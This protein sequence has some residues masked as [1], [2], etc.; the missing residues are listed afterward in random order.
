MEPFRQHRQ[1]PDVQRPTR[2]LFL[3]SCVSGGGAGRSLGAILSVADP[4][5]EPIVAMP[6][7]GVMA[8]RLDGHAQLVFV[9][10]FV[11]RM[12]RSPYTWPD[13]LH[14]SWLHPP[15]SVFSLLRC[16]R[17]LSGVVRKFEPD[18]IHCNHMLAKPVGVALGSRTGLPV[19]FH[20]R[21]CHQMWADRRLYERLGRHERV[22]RIICNSEASA[23]AYRRFSNDKVVIIPNGIDVDRYS[24]AATAT[25]LR[26]EFG[27]PDDRFVVGFVGRIQPSKGIGWLLRAFED[28]AGRC[29]N[30]VLA[31]VG[32][33]D[34]SLSNDAA[35]HYR[36]EAAALG[37]A[38]K[39]VFTGYR[40]DVRPCV[41]DLDMLVMPSLLPESF[42]RVLLEAMALEVPV[43]VAAHGGAVEV[44]RDGVEGLWVGVNDVDALA[45]AMEK[46]Y[47]DPPLRRTM[48]Q[49]GRR[50]V[51][52]C[53]DRIETARRVYDALIETAA[54]DR[55]LPSTAPGTTAGPP[56]RVTRA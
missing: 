16:I 29:T 3:N 35:A 50:R 36:R 48:G 51:T 11:E 23:A 37:L 55:R 45:G 6:V 18:V 43:V 14:L 40:D 15:A 31:V 10:E 39:T 52:A 38:D 5:V 42:G 9:P 20:S 2:V 47:S 1:D 28:F 53:Y 4:R 41:A 32:G 46:L 27:I 30:A 22:R 17:K 24:R 19:V 13:R 8:E 26:R 44:V 12:R 33:N 34:S 25:G 56:D 21:A 49:N 54:G 7:P